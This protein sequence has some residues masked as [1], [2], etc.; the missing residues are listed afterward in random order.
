MNLGELKPN[1]V[2]RGPL[3]PEP[4]QVVVTTPMAT[5]VK[6]IGRDDPILH[7]AKEK[8]E[9]ASALQRHRIDR[10]TL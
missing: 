10:T 2:L 4:V 1:R 5:A 9:A 6:L 3:F 8:K 7:V